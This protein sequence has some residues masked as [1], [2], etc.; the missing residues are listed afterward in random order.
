MRWEL[1]HAYDCQPDALGFHV[2]WHHVAYVLAMHQFPW[3]SV[4]PCQ[5]LRVNTSGLGFG[6]P[7]CKYNYLGSDGGIQENPFLDPFGLLAYLRFEDGWGGWQ[8]V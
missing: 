4:K 8:G 3:I 6:F 7:C 2:I 5:T 1:D